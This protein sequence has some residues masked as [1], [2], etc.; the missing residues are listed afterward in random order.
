MLL[1][2]KLY[3]N[4]EDLKKKKYVEFMIKLK[5]FNVNYFNNNKFIN[6]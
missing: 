4:R 5:V 2:Y 1:V 3:Y 6:K